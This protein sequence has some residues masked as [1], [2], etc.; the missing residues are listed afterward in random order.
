MYLYLT[1]LKYFI[2]S[3]EMLSSE[4]FTGGVFQTEKNLTTENLCSRP[5]KHIT[6]REGLYGVDF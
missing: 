6:Q 1:T 2:I 3:R 4:I 5:R